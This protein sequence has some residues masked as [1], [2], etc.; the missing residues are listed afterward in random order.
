MLGDTDALGG[1]DAA[2]VAGK[3]LCPNG[4][5]IFLNNL[6]VYFAVV[7]DLNALSGQLTDTALGSQ[8]LLDLL[9]S[10]SYVA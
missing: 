10:M 4:G 7:P 8:P 3:P 2:I 1:V 9:P 6:V 5:D